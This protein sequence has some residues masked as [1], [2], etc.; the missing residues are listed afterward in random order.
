MPPRTDCPLQARRS[1]RGGLCLAVLVL[2]TAVITPLPAHAWLGALSKLG[3]AAGKGAA[4]A[5]KGAAAG[6]GAVGGVE[7]MQGANAA[8]K[9]G[10]GAVAAEGAAAASADDISRASGLGKAVPDEVAAMLSTPGK[11]LLDVPD[12]GAR[13]WLGRPAA[14]LNPADAD[15]MVRDYAALL[16]GKPAAGPRQAIERTA[17]NPREPQLP[18]TRPPSQVPWYAFE[19]VAR[20]AHL[21]HAGAKAEKERL[22]RSTATRPAWGDACTP[23]STSPRSPLKS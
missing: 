6:A 21:G 14:K 19:L 16:Q 17:A 13:S 8:A 3:S 4:T 11:T 12:P 22:C 10:K 20:A 1:A 23:A 7:A 18:T 9:A 5:G 15:L 2:A